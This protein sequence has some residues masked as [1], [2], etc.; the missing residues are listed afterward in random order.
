MSSSSAAAA[1]S[2]TKQKANIAVIGAGWWAQG[3]HI[4][5]LHR[6]P[7][8][9]LA[10]IVNRSSQPSGSMSNLDSLSTLSEKYGAA[11]FHNITDMLKDPSVGPTL[12]GVVVVTAH[13]THFPM[14]EE[15]LHFSKQRQKEGK[16]P[17]H[18]FMEKPMTVNVHTAKQL[19]DMVQELQK[20][21]PGDTAK[22]DTHPFYFMLN[23]SAN[24]RTQAKKARELIEKGD[25]GQLRHISIFFAAPLRSLFENPE[26]KGWTQ[27]SDDMLG[28]GFGWGQSSH[29]LGWVLHVCPELEPQT[30]YCDMV[31]S[32]SSGADVGV[33]A[34]IR[35]NVPNKEFKETN[36]KNSEVVVSLSGTSLLPG[37][38]KHS[39]SPVGKQVQIM[40][41]GTKGAII[42]CGDSEDVKS[43]RLELRRTDT[44][45]KVEYPLGDD[46]GFDFE[47]LATEGTGPESLQ[48]FIQACLSN[49]DN[50]SEA[51]EDIYVGADSLVGLRAVQV[52]EAMYRSHHEKKAVQV[53]Q[54]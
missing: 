46:Y 45:G 11:T 25:I 24:Y 13:S 18:I 38:E 50:S 5:Q 40:I 35:C 42:Y 28:N 8:A 7:N 53:K 23:H 27:P 26:N 47:N 22:S 6:N 44:D 14:G 16:P 10:A 36:D 9:N 37:N 15:L 20:A 32:S 2:N 12:D 51:R 33:A 48:S 21:P 52:L 31:H 43:G 49:Y 34:T 17:L 3:W 54:D 19:H 41:Y 29:A 30:V 1:A 39:D 4:P